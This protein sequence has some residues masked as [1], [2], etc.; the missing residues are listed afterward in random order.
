MSM[1][2]GQKIKLLQAMNYRMAREEREKQNQ[3]MERRHNYQHENQMINIL[4]K[5]IVR[6]SEEKGTEKLRMLHEQKMIEFL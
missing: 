5:K 4:K 1:S 3:D 6:E 2:K